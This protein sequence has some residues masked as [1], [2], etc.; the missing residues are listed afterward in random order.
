MIEP[1]DRVIQAFQ[2]ED[3]ED[4]GYVSLAPDDVAKAGAC[5]CGPYG[6]RVPNAHADGIFAVEGSRKGPTFVNYLRKAFEWG[7]FP[8][9]EGRRGCPRKTIAQL[10]EG[11][12]PL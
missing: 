9:W 1:L 6:M 11:L 5:G 4:E 8:G 3:F 12:I 7:G 2:E 10:A